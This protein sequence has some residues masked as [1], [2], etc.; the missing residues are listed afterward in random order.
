MANIIFKTY[1]GAPWLTENFKI[2]SFIVVIDI[3]LLT[4]FYS[5]GLLNLL[6]LY[7]LV[8]AIKY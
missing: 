1:S 4:Y 3:F 5:I 7:F 2:F 8:I 6:F